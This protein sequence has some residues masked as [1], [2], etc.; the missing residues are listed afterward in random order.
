MKETAVIPNIILLVFPLTKLCSVSSDL[1]GL[2][3]TM[4]ISKTRSHRTREAGFVAQ[5]LGPG[6]AFFWGVFPG[7]FRDNFK[8]VPKTDLNPQVG[9]SC[10]NIVRMI[11][12]KHESINCTSFQLYG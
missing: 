6:A 10:L 3:A 1:L 2:L 8:N 7:V 5:Q 12:G 11:Y 4:C 9:L